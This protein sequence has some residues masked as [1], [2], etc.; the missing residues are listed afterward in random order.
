[1]DK[2][3]EIEAAD[4][5]EVEDLD[6]GAETDAGEQQERDYEAEARALGW[7]PPEDFPGDSSKF[8][9]A[10]TFV[11]RG[12]TMLPMVKAA[13][14]KERKEFAEFRKETRRALKFMGEAEKRGYERALADLQTRHDEAVEAGDVA[15]ARKAVK[16]MGELV[17][18]EVPELDDDKPDPRQAQREFAEWVE[19]NDWYV[20]DD[21]KRAYADIQ[22]G[23]MG[24]AEE[25]DGGPKAWLEELGKRVSRKFAEQKPNPANPGGNRGTGAPRGAKTY[26][27]LPPAA[28]ALCDKWH[29]T[30]VF[31]D[32]SKVTLEDARKRYVRDYDWS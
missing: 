24:P 17:K 10:K 12:E 32:P 23:A 6:T 1:M 19:Q 20:T 2:A 27:D 11:E 26:A 14:A 25:W 30:G 16:E 31:G 21:K 4:T 22:A 5:A 15:G 28:K 3:G 29:R 13:L 8:V 18:P 7:R 9:D